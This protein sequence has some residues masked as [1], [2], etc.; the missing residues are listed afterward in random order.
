MIFYRI[1]NELLKKISVITEL[2][3]VHITKDKALAQQQRPFIVS[4]LLQSWDASD[5]ILVVFW[6]K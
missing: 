3:G 1:E 6:V 5:I 4:N 2:Q